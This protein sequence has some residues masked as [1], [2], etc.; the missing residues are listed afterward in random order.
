MGKR[1]SRSV[2]KAIGAVV[3]GLSLCLCLAG[4]GNGS[5]SE[6]ASSDSS[7]SVAAL[8]GVSATGQSGQKPTVTFE[9]PMDIK[10]SSYAVVIKGTGQQVEAGDRVCTQDIVYNARTGEVIDSTWEKNTPVCTLDLNS[11]VKPEYAKIFEAQKVG[12]TIVFGVPGTGTPDSSTSSNAAN[13][14]NSS[15]SYL[16]ALTIVSVSR[17]L[18]RATGTA[19]ANI[20]AGLPKVTLAKN[21]APSI[22]MNN[23]KPTGQLVSQTLIQ[24]EGATLQADQTAV[25]KYTGWLLSNGKQFDSTW[26]KGDTSVDLQLSQ[27]VKGFQQGLVGQKVGS[28]VL[29]IIPPDLGYGS[30]ANGSIPANSTLVFVVDILGAYNS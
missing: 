30:T 19:V 22:D 2:L 17:D 4:C 27:T 29:L 10:Q 14:A 25:V 13:A 5:S 7:S 12:A 15:D 9:K 16:S 20:P 3:S 26:S 11:Q 21:G 18:T 24:G 23:Y 1:H 28:Q 8:E 6:P